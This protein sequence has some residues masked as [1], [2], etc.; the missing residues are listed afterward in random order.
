MTT[1]NQHLQILIQ[2]I[3]G[4][5]ALLSIGQ[6][7]QFLILFPESV[8]LQNSCKYIDDCT[9]LL[10]TGFSLGENLTVIKRHLFDFGVSLELLHCSIPQIFM[11]LES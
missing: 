9:T 1:P 7:S 10:L 8:C 3:K 4:H 11:T 5:I 6:S 2:N